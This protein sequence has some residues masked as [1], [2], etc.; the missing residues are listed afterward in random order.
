MLD[1]VSKVWLRPPKG[2]PGEPIEVEATPEI[3]TPW[4]VKG[5]TQCLPAPNAQAG[6][7]P[8]HVPSEEVDDAS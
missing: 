8:V 4:M 6:E 1:R 5:W 7:P 2:E 3:L